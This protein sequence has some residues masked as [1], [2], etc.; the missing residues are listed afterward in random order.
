MAYRTYMDGVLLPVTPAKI[1]MKINNQNKTLTLINGEEINFLK[2]AGLSSVSFELLLPQNKYPF[3]YGSQPADYYLS[4]FER[5]KTS[6]QPFQW[7]LNRSRPNGAALFYTNMKV[8]LEDYQIIEDA[9]EGLDI[10]VKVN[11]KQYLPF[12]TQTGTIKPAAAEGEKPKLVLSAWSRPAPTAPAPKTY[13]VQKGDSLWN[14]AKKQLGNGNR[15]SEI[16]ELN[17][18]KIKNA[19]LIYAGQVLVMP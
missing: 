19:S 1:T 16:Y 2:A 4:L 7:V 9:D 8:S 12:G 15:W 11:L 13:T 6:K 14:I 10:K 5:L 3:A 18:D 17:K